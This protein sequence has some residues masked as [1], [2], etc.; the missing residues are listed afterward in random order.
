[1]PELRRTRTHKVLRRTRRVETPLQIDT[2]F[3]LETEGNVQA[4][5]TPAKPGHFGPSYDFQGKAVPRTFIGPHSLF[6]DKAVPTVKPVEVTQPASVD[7]SKVSAVTKLTS[8]CVQ[9][10]RQYRILQKFSSVERYWRRLD[11]VLSEKTQ[12]PPG[13]LLTNQ[14]YLYRA[15]LEG[16]T[17]SAASRPYSEI[18]GSQYW[19]MSLRNQSV[20]NTEIYV[21]VGSALNGLYA[22]VRPNSLFPDFIRKPGITTESQQHSMVQQTASRALS[23]NQLHSL[24]DEDAEALCVAGVSKLRLETDAV[25]LVGHEFLDL[26]LLTRSQEHEEIIAE[27]GDCR[28][29][30][31]FSTFC[32]PKS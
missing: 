25:D 14:A 16:L 32:E 4:F 6:K 30:S 23:R 10:D 17:A 31:H 11:R 21:G 28:R 29:A 26:K 5:L 18:Y 24:T 15:K 12:K 9:E 2:D 7:E 20:P 19:K 27:H 1:M 13:E 22:K 3:V 8:E